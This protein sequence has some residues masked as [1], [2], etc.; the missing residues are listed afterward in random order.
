MLLV[1]IKELRGVDDRGKAYEVISQII[2]PMTEKSKTRGPD[3]RYGEV[4]DLDEYDGEI[5][6]FRF[7]PKKHGGLAS[8]HQYEGNRWAIAYPLQN[9]GRKPLPLW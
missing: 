2:G 9:G 7:A 5:E 3:D 4:D 1:E 8:A 6:Y